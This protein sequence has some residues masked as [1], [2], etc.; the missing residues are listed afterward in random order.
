MAVLAGHHL[1]GADAG[2]DGQ[3]HGLDGAQQGGATALVDLDGHQARGELDDAG[4][5][6]EPLE[7]AGRLQPEQT[8]ADD[9]AVAAALG[10]LLDGEEVLDGAV[11]E[12]ARGV[13]A[14]DGRHEREAAGG[15]DQDV[16][17]EHLP[18]PGGD[19]AGGPVDALGGVVEVEGDAVLLHEPG[20]RHGQVLGGAAGEVRGQVHAVVGGPGL[21]AEHG[22]PVRGGDPA[23]GE[24]LEVALADHAVPDEHDRGQGLGHVSGLRRR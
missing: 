11:D 6:A 17:R 16:V 18:G 22:D 12:T 4:G 10:V 5:E 3:P 2:V 21:L 15:Q 14:R 20:G 7:G 9:R 1:L 13:L 19:R 23:L 8:A 24:C